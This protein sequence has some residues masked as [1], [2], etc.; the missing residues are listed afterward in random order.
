M[1]GER[2]RE[3]EGERRRESGREKEGK[4]EERKTETE[5]V[6]DY[7]LP[8]I[9]PRI[10]LQGPHPPNTK[11]TLK[12]SFTTLPHKSYALLGL[13]EAYPVRAEFRPQPRKQWSPHFYPHPFE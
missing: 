10:P 1:E 5:G 4:R 8:L 3:G 7:A 9:N 11:Q 2:E 13:T 12:S 6:S